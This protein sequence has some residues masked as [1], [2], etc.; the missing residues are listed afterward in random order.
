MR[1]CRD[2]VQVNLDVEH[3][4]LEVSCAGPSAIR[5]HSKHGVILCQ[6]LGDEVMESLGPGNLAQP[7]QQCGPY[8][9]KMLIV[10]DNDCHLGIAG[11]LE[12]DEVRNSKQL[13]EIAG[14]ESAKGVLI[15]VAFGDRPRPSL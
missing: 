11:V 10:C 1:R 2:C 13:A 8:T 15:I 3:R 14:I 12:C 7:A 6:Y 4:T 9:T 5:K